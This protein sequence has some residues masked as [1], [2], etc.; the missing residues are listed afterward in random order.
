MNI[1]DYDYR[2]QKRRSR[3]VKLN[4]AFLGVLAVAVVLDAWLILHG[5]DW[6]LRVLDRW[7]Q[8]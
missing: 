3:E 6:A 1:N 2:A 7:L 4:R 8:R 5:V